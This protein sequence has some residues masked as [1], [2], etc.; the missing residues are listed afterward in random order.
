MGCSRLGF[1]G[2]AAARASHSRQV[3]HLSI[4]CVSVK[5]DGVEWKVVEIELDEW[6]VK[7]LE[8]ARQETGESP[9]NFI[10]RCLGFQPIDELTEKRLSKMNLPRVMP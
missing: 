10:R 5:I 1:S 3:R 4:G 6:Q 2:P 7:M 9:G 8:A